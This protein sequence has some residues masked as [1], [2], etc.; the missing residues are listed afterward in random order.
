V[1]LFVF[2][3]VLIKLLLP[4][5]LTDTVHLQL[6]HFVLASVAIKLLAPPFL[7]VNESV[8]YLSFI[9]GFDLFALAVQK[10]LLTFSAS[11]CK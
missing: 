10:S 4:V 11:C 9:L 1:K 8:E 3:L 5:L 6:D 7:D 2:E